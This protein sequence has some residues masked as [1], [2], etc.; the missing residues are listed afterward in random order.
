[1]TS[2]AFDAYL[3]EHG[4]RMR[5]LFLAALE[6]RPMPERLRESMAYSLLAGGK[7]LRSALCIKSSEL[8]GG[9]MVMA[10]R[11]AC[12][13]EM[14]HAYSL[15]HDDLPAMDND[16]MRRGK[17]SNHIVFGEAG[18]I[19]AGDGLLSLAFEIMANFANSEVLCAVAKGAFDMV[20]GQSM[21]IGVS[22]GE[23]ALHTIHR[24]KTGALIR[25]SVLAGAYCATP[26]PEDI[27]AISNFS[28]AFGLL[29]QITDDILDVCGNTET[30]GKSI[31]KDDRDG[32]LTF[33][34]CFGL[35]E[36]RR[37]AAEQAFAA[38]E[39][40]KVYGVNAAFFLAMVEATLH[41]GMPKDV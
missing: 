27:Y 9:D 15:V 31:G 38:K 22:S 21:D 16:D 11:A 32:K 8:L 19:L 13:I 6:T 40:I 10:E 24:L 29:F 37:Y 1:M 3:H 41:R 33:V 39:A 30:L 26:T 12:A 23:G 5:A 2:T 28:D 14:I 36:S 20:A 7:C 34:T 25:A 18:A 35:D 17:P 4:I